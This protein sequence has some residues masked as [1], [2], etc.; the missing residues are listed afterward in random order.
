MNTILLCNLIEKASRLGG[1]F[2]KNVLF[3]LSQ[4][5]FDTERKSRCI[6]VTIVV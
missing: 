1:F 5:V 4:R 2:Y 6:K 3:Y